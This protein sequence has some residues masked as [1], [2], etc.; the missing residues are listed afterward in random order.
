VLVSTAR[1]LYRLEASVKFSRLVARRELGEG[2]IE[3]LAIVKIGF[4]LQ[5]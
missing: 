5:H 2:V 3:G 1:G 4:I